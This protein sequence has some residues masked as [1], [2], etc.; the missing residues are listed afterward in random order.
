MSNLAHARVHRVTALYNDIINR[1]IEGL[2]ED[3]RAAGLDPG[4]HEGAPLHM[5]RDLWREK[6]RTSGCL[7]LAG[8]SA[9]LASA[10]GDGKS[11]TGIQYTDPGA[12]SVAVQ[13]NK[14]PRREQ[15]P[16]EPQLGSGMPR[17]SELYG[18]PV[19]DGEPD[20]QYRPR[21]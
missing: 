3:V 20:A 2:K 18:A 11:Y 16:A 7:D 10:V 15:K 13:Q 17:G 1:V 19:H 6:L 5:L 14:R 8:A 9:L 4:M 12:S 21:R